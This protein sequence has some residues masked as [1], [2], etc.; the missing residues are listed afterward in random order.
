MH[1]VL[2]QKGQVQI[3]TFGLQGMLPADVFESGSLTKGI[4]LTPDFES[5]ENLG[6][7]CHRGGMGLGS[8][9]FPTSA[10]HQFIFF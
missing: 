1:T 3:Q 2:S 7:S 10:C 9:T 8:H 4:W 5:C 6:F